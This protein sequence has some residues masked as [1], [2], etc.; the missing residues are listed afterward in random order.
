MAGYVVN[1]IP[2][3]DREFAQGISSVW[4]ADGPTLTNS[5][6]ISRFATEGSI[7]AEV[8]A[9]DVIAFNK[10]ISTGISI[11]DTINAD[12]DA[13]SDDAIVVGFW[14]KSDASFSFTLTVQLLFPSDLVTVT[15]FQEKS[16]LFSV[17]SGEWTF[18]QL[19]DRVV[20]ENDEY[21]YPI[22]FTITVEEIFDTAS[23][24]INIAHPVIYPS[25][26]FIDNPALL[27]IYKK[28]PEF[29]R[30]ADSLGTNAP[31]PWSL[32]R[33]LEM[34]II[35]QGEMTQIFN[36]IIYSDISL[37][38]DTSDLNTLSTLVDPLAA[39]RKHIFW[40]AQFTGTQIVNPT[41]GVTPWENLP[42]TWQGIDDLDSVASTED[43]APW[44]VIQDSNPEPVGLDDFLRWQVQYGYYGINAGSRTAIL[45]SVKRVLTG[46]KEVT[47]SVP[48]AWNIL[49]E[50]NISETPDASLLSAGDP[51]PSILELVEYTRPLGCVIAHELI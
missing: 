4:Q 47:Y 8:A 2:L 51:V 33:F 13:D 18:I 46:T 49:I 37:G 28:L 1:K 17:T 25:I 31:Y 20:V 22:S 40:L 36:D 21:S 29:I 48:S 6:L 14:V 15:A 38:K 16:E 43:S 7:A 3:A 5:A 45:E 27:S 26:S 19:E 11:V 41:T 39:T 23:A 32:A 12:K 50:T 34:C 35:H 42:S 24:N 44:D 10:N 9:D 30:N